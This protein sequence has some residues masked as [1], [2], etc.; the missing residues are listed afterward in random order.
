MSFL[1]L[2]RFRL[3]KKP[4][5]RKRSG[6]TP[7]QGHD[8]EGTNTPDPLAFSVLN[9]VAKPKRTSTV[10]NRTASERSGLTADEIEQSS[11]EKLKLRLFNCLAS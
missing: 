5:E 9:L 7:E 8:E 4:V 2:R 3:L 1:T 10:Y 6:Y 11:G